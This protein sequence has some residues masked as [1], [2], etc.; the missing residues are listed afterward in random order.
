MVFSFPPSF[1]LP[2]VSKL[3]KLPMNDF[4]PNNKTKKEILI[5]NKN[6]DACPGGSTDLQEPPCKHRLLGKK[7]NRC[8]LLRRVARL[9]AK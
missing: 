9:C 5:K 2:I 7:P 8:S 1:H 6:S 3:S 4:I